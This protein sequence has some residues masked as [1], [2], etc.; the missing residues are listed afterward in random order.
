MY[1]RMVGI[2]STRLR[3]TARVEASILGS[4]LLDHDRCDW[5]FSLA[6]VSLC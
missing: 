4:V 2:E 5:A 3:D 1:S 6:V